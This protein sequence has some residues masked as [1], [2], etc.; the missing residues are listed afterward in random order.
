MTFH[1]SEIH[2][3]LGVTEGE[4]IGFG[5]RIIDP[6]IRVRSLLVKTTKA[7]LPAI[8]KSPID[9]TALMCKHRDRVVYAFNAVLVIP[10]HSLFHVRPKRPSALSNMGVYRAN[11]YRFCIL[12]SIG[13]PSRRWFVQ[14]SGRTTL[15]SLDEAVQSLSDDSAVRVPMI[16]VIIILMVIL[17]MY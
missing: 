16:I 11:A 17:T 7:V 4:E 13:S 14:P 8:W 15:P 1:R 9:A 3:R 2:T 5:C 12:T 6:W 10:S